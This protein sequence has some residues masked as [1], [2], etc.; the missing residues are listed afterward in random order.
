MLPGQA[1]RTARAVAV[2]RAVGVAGVRDDVV[3]RLL[4]ARDRLLVDALRLLRPWQVPALGATAHAALRMQAVDTALTEA[5]AA[6]DP[7]CVVVVGAGYDTRAWRLPVLAGRRVVEIDHP[8]TQA[9]KRRHLGDLPALAG[10]VV[11]APADLRSDD[12]DDVLERAGQ[13]IGDPVVWVWEA[14]VPYLPGAAVDETLAVLAAR[15]PAGSRLLLTT[16][17]PQLLSPHLPAV[18]ASAHLGLRV[19]GEPVL[20]AES[21][22]D[23]TV[24]LARHGW[25]GAGGRG[26]H[27]WAAAA[28]VRLLGPVLDERL[29]VATRS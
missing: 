14:V 21:D 6:V 3:R 8:A 10:D 20:T 18:R 23:V 12:L 4:P 11:L 28:D 5:V 9:A 17:T 1:S 24:R 16:L 26:P 19:I 7:E 15:S 27:D 22:A 29:H 13:T 25:E 2:G